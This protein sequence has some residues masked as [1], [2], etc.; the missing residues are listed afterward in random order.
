LIARK[1][2]D[3]DPSLQSVKI[4][5]RSA[6]CGSCIAAQMRERELV[7]YAGGGEGVAFHPTVPIF[8]A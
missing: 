5:L 3:G 6:C 7:E 8:D 1:D 2:T 4:L